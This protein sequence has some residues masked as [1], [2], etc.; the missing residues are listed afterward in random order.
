MI[1]SRRIAKA[2]RENMRF[3]ALAA[4]A[5][6]HFT[7]IAH[8]VSSMGEEIKAV[9]VDVLRDRRSAGPDRPRGSSPRRL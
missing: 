3:I 1:S 9:F 7:T 4:D 2:C 6:P 5:Q 8:V